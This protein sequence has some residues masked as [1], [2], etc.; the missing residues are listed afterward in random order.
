MAHFSAFGQQFQE[1][2]SRATGASVLCIQAPLGS[3]FT[4]FLTHQL[5]SEWDVVTVA[6]GFP[7][8]KQFL[9]DVVSSK[10]S[11]SLRRKIL[12]IDPIDALFADSVAGAELSEFAKSGRGQVPIVVSGFKQRTSLNRVKEM[13]KSR[14]VEVMVIAKATLEEAVEMLCVEF[15]LEDS[16]DLAKAWE[17]SN[18]DLRAT[19][20]ALQ[21]PL[22]GGSKDISYDGAE[23]LESILN[24]PC[25]YQKAL[26]LHD[27]DPS[28]VSLGIFE[29]YHL[30]SP[31]IST[32]AWIADVYSI[33]DVIDEAAYGKQHWDLVP[34]YVALTSAA[35]S[36]LP[37]PCKKKVQFDKFGT[38]WSKEN[39]ARSK[40]RSL[41]KVLT[42]RATRGLALLPTTDMA[43]VR[44]IISRSVRQG[45]V[46]YVR[47]LGM[48]AEEIINIMRLWKC[49]YTLTD[50]AKVKNLLAAAADRG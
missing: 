40:A 24:E 42:A 18:G 11:V 48:T 15:P 9:T 17:D 5:H 26:K 6:T 47:T 38:V 37:T 31:D 27:G 14:H 23:A 35:A 20:H 16:K 12:V 1:W 2:L 41:G 43:F 46:R 45:T 13:F 29:N 33:A 30:T 10:I 21:L 7:K 25:S 4:T 3:G 49:K 19:R 39:N 34:Y 28:M 32:C 8:L 50:H 22:P 44:N 36:Q